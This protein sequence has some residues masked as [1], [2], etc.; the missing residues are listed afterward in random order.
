MVVAVQL[1]YNVIP[2]V[3]EKHTTLRKRC[4]ALKSDILTKYV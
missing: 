1:F 4:L 3:P 2:G